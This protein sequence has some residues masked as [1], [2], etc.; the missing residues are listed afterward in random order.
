MPQGMYITHQM[1]EFSIAYVHAIASV[2][3]FAVERFH[4]DNDSAD[5]TVRSDLKYPV[6]HNP[7]I[8]LQLKCSSSLSVGLTTPDQF[9][10]P[11]QA[12]NYEALSSTRRHVPMFLVLV[13]APKKPAHWMVQHNSVQAQLRYCAYWADLKGQPP[14]SSASTVSI[15]IPRSQIFDHAVLSGWMRRIGNGEFL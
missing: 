4:V 9:T 1:E 8:E 6:V 7:R 3:G 5:V 11:L 13:H 12:N 10:Y 14:S 2:A 15:H